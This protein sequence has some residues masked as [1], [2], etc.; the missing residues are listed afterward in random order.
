MT[1]LREHVADLAPLVRRVVSLDRSSLVRLR[2]YGGR[3][4]AVVRLPF[5]VLA[6]RTVAL[7]ESSADVE[8]VTV[9]S[10]ELLAWLD[11]ETDDPPQPRDTEWR[12]GLPPISGWKRI[13]TVPDRDVRPLVRSG[14]LALQEAAR[15]EGVP[16]A[17]PRAEV[18]DALLDSVVLTVA[19]ASLRVEVTLRTLSAVT[20]LGF[21]PAGSYIAV[22]VAARWVRVAAAY[23]SVYAERPGASLGLTAR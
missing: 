7:E 6:A 2:R 9:R 18:A 10:G 1:L 3:V 14:A 21:L 16:G 12:S 13:D 19:D 15:R 11:G 23:G 17:Q 20:R 22:D 4:S 5:G 8:D